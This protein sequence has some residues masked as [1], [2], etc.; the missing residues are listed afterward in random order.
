MITSFTSI[1]KRAQ[2]SNEA[3][4]LGWTGRTR[5]FDLVDHSEVSSNRL[6]MIAG[7]APHGGITHSFLPG[8]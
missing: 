6:L 2:L 8:V 5:D 1:E 7:D 3:F 4:F